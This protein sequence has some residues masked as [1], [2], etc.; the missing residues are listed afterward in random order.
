MIRLIKII[1]AIILAAIISAT[2][3]FT[4]LQIQRGQTIDQGLVSDLTTQLE[5]TLIDKAIDKTT[6]SP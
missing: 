4:Y 2:V 1:T 6:I 3:G 5:T